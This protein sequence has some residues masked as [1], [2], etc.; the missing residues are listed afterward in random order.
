MSAGDP[1]TPAVIR[2]ERIARLVT[3]ALLLAAAL[4][5]VSMLF[6]GF[7]RRSPSVADLLFSALNV[8]VAPS[9]ASVVLLA[10]LAGGMQRR[11]RLALA[12]LA[13]LQVLGAVLSVIDLVQMLGLDPSTIRHPVPLWT[14]VV[15]NGLSPVVAIMVLVLLWRLRDRFPARMPHGSRWLALLVLAVGS[16]LTVGVTALWIALTHEELGVDAT[17]LVWSLGHSLGLVGGHPAGAAPPGLGWTASTLTGLTLAATAW[18]FLRAAPRRTVRTPDQEVTLRA[19]LLHDGDRDSLSY[20]ATR[21]DKELVATAGDTSMVAFRRLGGVA[22]AAGDPVGPSTRDH[23]AMGAF[24]TECRTHGWTPAV[25]SASEEAARR[26]TEHGMIAVRMGDEAVLRPEEFRLSTPAMTPV[27]RAVQHARRAGLVVQVRRHGSLSEQERSRLVELADS[28]REGG[29]ERGFSMA[30]SRLGDPADADCL[31]VTAEIPQD[32]EDPQNPED[33]DQA[34]GGWKALL[35]FVPWGRSGLS[36]DVMRRSP[37]APGGATELMIAELM[38]QAPELGVRRVSLN[39]AMFRHVLVEADAVDAGPGVRIG[40]LLLSRADRWFQLERLAR[41]NAKYQPHWVPRYLLVDSLTALPTSALAA[42]ALEGFAPLWGAGTPLEQQLPAELLERTRAD[43][44]NSRQAVELPLLRRSEQFT[45]RL[46]HLERLRQAGMAPYPVGLPQPL[47]F[48]AAVAAVHAGDPDDEIIVAGRVRHVREHGAVVF[49]DLCAGRESLQII[50]DEASTGPGPLDLWRR[51]VD[52]G[53]LVHLTGRPGHSRRGTPSLLVDSWAMA[54]KALH[55]VPFDGLV[56]PDSRLRQRSLDL[57]VHPR[58]AGLLRA[59][60]TVLTAVREQLLREGAQE[61]ETPIL[62]SVHGGA[63]ARP[64][65][66]HINAYDLDLSLRIA[67]ELALKRLLVGG[68]GPIFEIGRNFRNEGADATHN[69]EFTS[70]ETY[71]PFQDYTDMRRLTERLVKAAARSLYGAEVLPLRDVRTAEPVGTDP[72]DRLQALLTDVSG[73]WP[74]IP[75][76][77]AVSQAVGRRVDVETD[78]DELT[79]LAAAHEV[80]LRGDMGPGA[81]L[82]ELY[83]ELVEPQTIR[84][85]FYTDFPAETSPLTAP[86]RTRP[87]LVERWDLV[88][89]GMEIGTAYSELTDPIDQRER[90]TAQSLKAAAGDPE[91]M[92]IDEDFLRALEAGMPPAGGLGIGM[93]RLVMLLTDTTI[94][95]IL[96]FPFVRPRQP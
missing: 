33:P 10:L 71:W 93:D 31:L 1:R 52:L 72:G 56:D 2:H 19:L 17:V 51:T 20:F 69:P 40:S 44:A 28:W 26:W 36:L 77:E 13:G 15:A 86:H 64:F 58:G 76:A 66:T 79:A 46:E 83:G 74:A 30:L 16:A 48:P 75:M 29:E 47:P 7:G 80:P 73:P 23:E 88:A 82:E 60:S 18:T 25:L 3:G 43:A 70:L 12:A 8:P 37:G 91:A 81:V 87:G 54:A 49:A 32:P 90:F 38:A 41:S 50:L 21:R 84:P 4:S 68:L 55:P 62:Q 27:R 63:N 45:H 95:D 14:M 67:P 78:I 42:M 92:E 35:S 53:D 85:T 96:T 22:M 94:R 57:V 11:K 89:C 34:G 9:F 59:R 6:T 65:S 39:F 24:I 61:V 5:V